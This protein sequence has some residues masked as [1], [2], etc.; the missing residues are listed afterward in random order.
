[1]VKRGSEH[2]CT[3]QQ[4]EVRLVVSV[5][6]WFREVVSVSEWYWVV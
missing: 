4:K 3:V 2:V 5:S 1:M 6:E